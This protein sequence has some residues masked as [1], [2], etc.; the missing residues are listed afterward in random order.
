MGLV[1]LFK[2][3]IDIAVVASEWQLLSHRNNTQTTCWKGLLPK[4][5]MLISG[6]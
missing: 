5:T 3:C 6:E 4:S 1:C 2:T